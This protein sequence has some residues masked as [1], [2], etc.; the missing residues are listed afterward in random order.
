M[1]AEKVRWGI[2]G[3]AGIAKRRVVPAMQQSQHNEV[4]AI[5][6]RTIDKAKAFAGELNIPKAYGSYEELIADPNIDAIYNPLPNSE[7][8]TWSILC[9]EAGKPTLC[10]KPLAK[11][12]TEA[13]TIV[14]AFARR[15]IL[16]AEGF[17]YRFHPQTVKVKELVDSGVV[18]DFTSMQATFTFRIRSEEDIRLSKPLAGGGLMDVG[19]YC[20]NVMRLMT[21]QEP[22]RARAIARVGIKSGVDEWLAGILAF[23]SG[24]IGHFDCGVRAQRTHS[25]EIRGTEG[26]I[27]VEAGF[28]AEPHESPVIRIWRG[29]QYEEITIPGVN[30]YTLMADDFAEALLN[31]RPPRYVP[32]DAVDNMRAIDM[33]YASARG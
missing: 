18:G 23:P 17:M 30:Q 28:V 11:D 16:F 5:A 4:V 13:Q 20:V 7:H 12:A 33:L 21:G 9:A 31:N 1:M 24:V 8:A 25:Y 26:R 32:Q 29:D 19:C 27:L 2:L 10:E 15:N 22:E 3:A 14:D 6:S